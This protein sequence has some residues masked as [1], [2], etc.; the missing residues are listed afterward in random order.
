MLRLHFGKIEAVEGEPAGW[1]LVARANSPGNHD[2]SVDNI[3]CNLLLIRTFA[4]KEEAGPDP[5]Q[6]VRPRRRHVT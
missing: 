4:L 1:T 6:L 2:A 5:G 3:G